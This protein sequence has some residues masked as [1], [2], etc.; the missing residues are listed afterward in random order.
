MGKIKLSPAALQDLQEIKTYIS[1]DLSNP[2]AAQRTVKQIVEDYMLLE[3]SPFMGPSLSA[4]IH[5]ET[6]Y[7]YLV[8]GSYIIFYKVSNEEVFIYRILNGR[9]DYLKILFGEM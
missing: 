9:M 2:I 8:S 4:I 7:R 5:I 1:E 6:D 3:I